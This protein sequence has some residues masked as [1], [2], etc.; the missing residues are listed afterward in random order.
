MFKNVKRVIISWFTQGKVTSSAY[1]SVWKPRFC[2]LTERSM[3]MHGGTFH[4]NFCGVVNHSD[5]N[6][7]NDVKAEKKTSALCQLGAIAK[8]EN[9]GIWFQE[10]I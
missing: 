8:A 1:F 7:Y 2:T 10:K 9:T 6:S 5:E 3:L 4:V